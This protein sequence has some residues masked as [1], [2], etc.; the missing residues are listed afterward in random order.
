MEKKDL[1]ACEKWWQSFPVPQ[2]TR[3][4]SKKQKETDI[5]IEKDGFKPSSWLDWKMVETF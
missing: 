2:L 3:S 4:M 1:Q 5:W